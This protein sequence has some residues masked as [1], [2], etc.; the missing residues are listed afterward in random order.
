[1]GNIVDFLR[2]G[3]LPSKPNVQDAFGQAS[4]A[5]AY[6]IDVDTGAAA[7]IEIA[8]PLHPASVSQVERERVLGARAPRDRVADA[9]RMWRDAIERVTIELPPAASRVVNSLYANLGYI[10][11]NRDHA[12]LQPGSRSY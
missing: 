1:Q 12:G 6:T 2:T 8:L 10:L 3:S 11:V 7:V 5:L 9:R 4:G